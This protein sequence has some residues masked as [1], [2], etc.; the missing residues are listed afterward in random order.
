[1]NGHPRS[2]SASS[3]AAI[4]PALP[5]V[6]H[7]DI[8]LDVP[9]RRRLDGLAAHLRKGEP[10]LSATTAFGPRVFTG[11]DDGPAVYLED[12][13]EIPLSPRR[14]DTPLQYRALLL[15]GDGDCVV[16][17]GAR[18]P[19][20]E[21]YCRE[22][23]ALGRVTVIEVAPSAHDPTARIAVRCAQDP[24]ALDSILDLAQRHGR[25]SIVPYIGTGNV[26]RLAGVIAARCGVKVSVAAPPPRLTQRVNDKLWFASRVTEVLGGGAQPPTYHA[27][28]PAALAGRVATLAGRHE[29]V[30]IKVPDSAG[31]AGNLVIESQTVRHIPLGKLRQ[32]LMRMMRGLGWQGDFPLMVAVWVCPALASPSVQM[33][34][35]NRDAGLPIVEG[36]FDQVLTGTAGAF[37]G[38]VPST[39]PEPWQTRMAEGA[40]RLA[41]LFQALG[42]FGRCSFDAVITGDDY[43]TAGLHWIECNGRWGGTSIPMTLAN[44]L[45]GDW[46]QRS[47]LIA[48]RAGV[49]AR[50]D[51][52]A[53]ALTRLEPALLRGGEK[54]G[55]VLLTPGGFAEDSELCVLA[56]AASAAETEGLVERVTALLGSVPD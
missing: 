51:D 33:W 49:N 25:L 27:F 6:P 45:V 50:A 53:G 14:S 29:R 56:L 23:L 52:F 9:E 47:M 38:A 31:S 21:A 7:A 5:I 18:S 41:Y 15:A 16:I 34:V 13:G 36:L 39:V 10:A 28:G 35:P 8:R 37:V 1:M 4:R 44:R 17:D 30:V 11:I 22:R 2:A 43:A 20:F 46:A 3:R 24:A 32:R 54:T 42:Y 40:M 12:H 26:W 48:Q 55:V 19:A